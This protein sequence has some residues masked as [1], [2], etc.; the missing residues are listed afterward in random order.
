M[1][2]DSITITCI[3]HVDI[4]KPDFINIRALINTRKTN[5]WAVGCK[6]SSPA[7]VA[8]LRQYPM[9]SWSLQGL[10][11]SSLDLRLVQWLQSLLQPNSSLLLYC[12]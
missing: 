4:I 11:P 1:H 9:G 12:V 10:S 8:V 2:C 3:F 5:C 7:F 6:L